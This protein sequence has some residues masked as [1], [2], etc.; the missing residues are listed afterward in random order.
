MRVGSQAPA[1]TEGDWVA[2]ELQEQPLE[3]EEEPLP[4]LWPPQ[5]QPHPQPQLP[6]VPPQLHV[7]L[8]GDACLSGVTRRD[9]CSWYSIVMHQ[10]CVVP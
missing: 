1:G 8:L 7:L 5:S 10:V 3:D 2:V 6:F 4:L 9:G